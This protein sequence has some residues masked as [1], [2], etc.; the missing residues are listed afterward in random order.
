MIRFADRLIDGGTVLDI[1]AGQGRNALFLARRGFDVHTLE[2]S[3]VAATALGALAGR[4]NLPFS[5]FTDPFGAFHPPVP[6]Y[7]GILVF[8]LIPDLRRGEITDLAG[9]VRRWSCP[10]ALLWVTAFTTEDPAYPKWK[11]GTEEIDP[12]S[13]RRPDGRVRTYLEPGEILRLFPGFSPIHHWEGLG[14]EHRHGD[15]QPERH[16]MAEAVFTLDSL[17]TGRAP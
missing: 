13:F 5:V 12:R 7:A 8:G 11:T 2:P 14:P 6:S 9:R 4:E 10:G 3:N 1:G 15:G 16:G 17:P